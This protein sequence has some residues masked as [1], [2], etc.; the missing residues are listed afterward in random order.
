MSLLSIFKVRFTGS[1]SLVLATSF[2]EVR[3]RKYLGGA[4]APPYIMSCF[5]GPELPAPPKNSRCF[6]GTTPQKGEI[7]SVL[8]WGQSECN[9]GQVAAAARPDGLRLR[10]RGGTH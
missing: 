5:C 4:A 1:F 2:T 9:L 6:Q 10:R 7:D 8:S 3:H